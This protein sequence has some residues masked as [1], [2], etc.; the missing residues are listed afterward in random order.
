MK[1]ILLAVCGLSP[2]VITE[3]LYALHQ[4]QR[5]VD[6][7]HVITTRSGKEKIYSGLLCGKTGPYYQY[8]K[9]FGMNPTD[10]AFGHDHIHVITDE[11][12]NEIPDITDE[13]DNERLLKKCLELTFHLTKN[14]DHAVF[15][16]IAGGR[17]TMSAC[18]SLAA[19]MY[20]RTQDRMF[21]VLVSPEFE[22]SRDFYYPPKESR[23]IELMD[24]TRQPYLKKTEFARIN[25]V[26][27]PFVSIRDQLSSDM[28]KRPKDPATLM[29][30]LIKDAPSRLRVNLASRKITHKK[31]EEDL[32]PTHMAIYAFFAMLK[33]ACKKGGESCG[34]C[35][36]CFLGLPEIMDRKDEITDI[37]K[38]IC[39]SRPVEEMSKTGIKKLDDINFNSYKSKINRVLKNKFGM[40]AIKDLEIASI[41]K[42]PNTRFGIR[43]DKSR[44]EVVI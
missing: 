38:R 19:Q 12:G 1:T 35:M 4:D 36:E 11:N 25:L 22:S 15:F 24:E 41:G 3:T 16:S 14:P 32:Y 17:K 43:M 37:Y 26:P 7:I 44:I 33:K 2:Q 39:G 13:K 20:G 9:D 10:I 30:S 21:H 18:L 42:R 23:E 6:A 31:M 40:Y 28:L 8:L 5:T 27:L 29:M 34:V